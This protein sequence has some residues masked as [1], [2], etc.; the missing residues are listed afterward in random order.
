M[1]MNDKDW[2]D[3][4]NKIMKAYSKVDEMNKRTKVKNSR[5]LKSQQE[6]LDELS[7]IEARYKTTPT[8]AYPKFEQSNVKTVTR[9]VKVKI[10]N[11]DALKKYDE[12]M[13]SKYTPLAPRKEPSLLEALECDLPFLKTMKE[14]FNKFLDRMDNFF[15]KCLFMKSKI[16]EETKPET[17]ET[18]K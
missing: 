8:S 5:S 6:I 2:Y 10:P 1:L 16:K 7:K 13:Y 12:S 17:K 9:T 4:Y 15:Y 3:T 14:D 18:P 11:K